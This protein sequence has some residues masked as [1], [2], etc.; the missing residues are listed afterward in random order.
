LLEIV[1]LLACA[2]SPLRGE[3][4]FYLSA[5]PIGMAT[6]PE[7]SDTLLIQRGD[8]GILNLFVMTDVRLSNISLN[9]RN[10]GDA[11]TLIGADV[12]NEDGPNGPR[13]TALRE[14]TIQPDGL[15]SIG[16]SAVVSP[17]GGASGI[18]PD[19]L[20]PGFDP[21]SG[22]LLATLNYTA[23]NIRGATSELFMQVG[24]SNVNQWPNGSTS[25]SVRLGGPNHDL[26]SGDVPGATDSLL[27]FRIRVVPE[28][29]SITL[30]ILGSLGVVTFAYRRRWN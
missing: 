9:V 7:P 14:G 17:Q 27:D 3:P 24:S 23:A 21:V 30:A 29:G 4:I 16:G 19:S 18:G 1:C 28:P 13:W 22:Y 25:I 15:N 2:A 5:D 6:P 10:I 20:D 12:P 26:V 8:S 11:I